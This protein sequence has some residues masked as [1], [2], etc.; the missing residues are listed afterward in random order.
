MPEPVAL[1]LAVK[2]LNAT[3]GPHGLVPPF[4]VFGQLPRFAGMQHTGTQTDRMVPMAA[5]R[6]EADKNMCE[7]QIKRALRSKLPPATS[8]I[9]GDSTHTPSMLGVYVDDILFA[10]TPSM[11]LS[12]DAIAQRFED[13]AVASTDLGG[14]GDRAYDRRVHRPAALLRPTPVPLAVNHLLR[15]LPTAEA[16]DR[17]VCNHP[18]RHPRCSQH[19]IADRSDNV[20]SKKDLVLMN[21]VQRRAS[22]NPQLRAHVPSTRTL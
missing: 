17:E 22:V 21:Q 2:A 19:H 12:S 7:S 15:E 1:R 5:A 3:M 10:G 9:Y 14:V 4:P 6:E 18:A 8:L 20:H 13:R 11:V 16:P